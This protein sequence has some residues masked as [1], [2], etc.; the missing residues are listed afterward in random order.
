MMRIWIKLLEISW[1]NLLRNKRRSLLTLLILMM[2]MS[3]L[4]LIGGYF[5]G[6][7][8]GFQEIYIHSQTGHLQVSLKGY[9]RKGASDPFAFLIQGAGRIEHYLESLPH[10]QDAFPRLQFGGMV[11]NGQTQMGVLVFATDPYSESKMGRHKAS[12]SIYSATMISAGQDL[13]PSDPYGAVLGKGLIEALGLK[14]GDSLN[15]IT[16]QP[17]GALE[18]ADF[19]IR[20]VFSAM[21]K[22]FDERLMKVNLAT[23]QKMLGLTDQAHVLVTV[24]DQTRNLQLP[25]TILEKKI[26]DEKLTWE[27]KPWSEGAILYHQSKDL[28]NRIFTVVQVIV[29]VVF[30]FSIANVFT[31]ALMERTREFGTMMAIGNGRR[32]IFSVVVLEGCILGMMGVALGLALGWLFALGI[33]SLGIEMP[34]PPQGTQPFLAEIILYPRLLIQTSL[35][36]WIVTVLASLIPAYRVSHFPITRALGYV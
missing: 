1:R 34:P 15:F 6:L 29:G 7:V 4:M 17:D 33:N 36:T 18:G 20:G 26:F 12:N 32:T 27:V 31:M 35:L 25:Q 24:L 5:R 2:G 22:D 8:E 30:F 3:G 19:H 23:A 28:L 11:G 9:S 16:H 13:D 10:V 14:V 21:V